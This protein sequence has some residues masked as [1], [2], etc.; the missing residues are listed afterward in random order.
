VVET[1]LA[2]ECF[3]LNTAKTRIMQRSGRQRVTG[4][5]VN[6]HCNVGRA[7]F[8]TLKAILNNCSRTG[9]ALQNRARVPDFRGHLMGRAA[10]VE[11]VNP[12]RGAKPRLLFDR[13]DWSSTSPPPS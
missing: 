13:I 8:D 9:P 1:I 6:E 12:L 11:Q 7:G 10:W 2:E 4:I 3:S 5:V